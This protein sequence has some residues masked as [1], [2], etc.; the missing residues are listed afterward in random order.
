MKWRQAL[1]IND[2]ADKERHA[3]SFFAW[4]PKEPAAA[5]DELFNFDAPS[6]P[7]LDADGQAIDET[8]APVNID[9]E[10][11]VAKVNG[12]VA[13]DKATKDPVMLS[14]FSSY[15]SIKTF[16]QKD[17]NPNFD[18]AENVDDIDDEDWEGLEND[19]D[20]GTT[21]DSN[22]QAQQANSNSLSSSFFLFSSFLFS[23]FSFP[24]FSYLK[25][26]P[27][28]WNKSRLGLLVGTCGALIKQIYN[29][30]NTDTV[31]TLKITYYR[32]LSY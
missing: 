10:P 32:Y 25:T 27:Q 30:L 9:K 4:R 12:N 6:R 5:R 8:L 15:P 3:T 17:I 21:P 14:T 2:K 18:K 11:K 31:F 22:N 23:F 29:K 7:S 24:L 28:V 26:P 16:D 13:N 19:H 20:N 1:E